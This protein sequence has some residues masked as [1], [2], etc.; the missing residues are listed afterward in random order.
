MSDASQ[1]ILTVPA[2]SAALAERAR[3]LPVMDMQVAVARRRTIAEAVQQLMVDG[4]DYGYINPPDRRKPGE[5][6]FLHQPG[7]QKLDNLFGLVPRFIV[8]NAEEDWTGERHGGEPFFRYLIKCQLW[9]GDVIMGEAIGECNSWESKYRWRE[10]GRKCPACQVASIIQ[11]KHKSGKDQGKPKSFW[12]APFKGGCGVGFELNDKAITDQQT[13]RVPNPDIFDQVNTLVKMAQKR[14][15]VAATIN[16]TSGSEFFSQDPE[17][18]GGSDPDDG[19]IGVSAEQRIA[20]EKAKAAATAEP[21]DEALT[22]LLHKVESGGEEG[23]LVCSDIFEAIKGHVG[24]DFATRAFKE[25]LRQH[26]D[27]AKLAKE[28]QAGA[29]LPIVR[30]LYKALKDVEVRAKK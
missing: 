17:A 6:A 27:P 14:A 15:H 4:Q 5:K 11:T 28:Q 13:G 24:A 26:G 30:V 3:F 10:G 23:E 16:A 8:D 22:K 21:D 7:A 19:P 18:V 1:A 25:A 29:Y 9:R 20:E 12:C 2:D